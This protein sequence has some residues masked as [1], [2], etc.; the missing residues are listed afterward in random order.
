MKKRILFIFILFLAM[1][2]IG[3][4]GETPEI[5]DEPNKPV[6]PEPEQ[7]I[8]DLVSFDKKE[9]TCL[10]DGYEAYEKCNGCDYST[11]KEI[12]AFGHE[13]EEVVIKEAECLEKGLRKNFKIDDAIVE[14]VIFRKESKKKEVGIL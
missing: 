7:H 4:G 2:M 8:H 14:E 11:F 1:F 13:Y 5:P 3:C 12:K 10:E 6:E 9:A